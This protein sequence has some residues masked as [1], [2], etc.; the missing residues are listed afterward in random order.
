MV[1][2]TYSY[3]PD[4]AVPPGWVLDEHLKSQSL[5]PAE[6]ARRCGRSAKLISEIIAGKAPV[7]PKTALQF[8]KVLGLDANI[9]LGM[10]ARYRLHLAREAEAKET[11][12]A[13]VW[14]KTFPVKELV[15][16]GKIEKPGSE[17][18]A[19]PKLLAFFGVGSVQVWH[20]R[21]EQMNVAYRHSRSFKSDRAAL[22]A[23]L[24]LGEI[25]AE[26]QECADYNAARFK[27]ALKEIRALTRAPVTSG[28]EKAQQLCNEAGVALAPIEPFRGTALSGAAWWL[29][30][31]KAVIALSARHKTD[32]HLWFSLF[33]ESAHILLH[34]KKAVFIDGTQAGGKVADI[35]TQADQWASDF[36]VSPSQWERFRVFDSYSESYIGQFAEEQGIA[37][38]IVVGRLQHEGRLSWG[39]RLNKLKVRLE[40]GP[41]S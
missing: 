6:F 7:E 41:T 18:D 8:E 15:K 33:H 38:G 20:G 24:R 22:T 4:Y 2:S 39:T 12:S 9:W 21:Y 34:S 29:N 1:A 40:W 14:A 23:W 16:R 36:F 27:R 11:R 31:R 3:R 10:E 19:V 35:E 28:L 37:P 32:D 25:E 30:R 5:S 17:T 26:Q 13:A